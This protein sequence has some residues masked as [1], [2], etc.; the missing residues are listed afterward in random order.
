MAILNGPQLPQMVYMVPNSV[1]G[2]SQVQ[3][4]KSSFLIGLEAV[5][6]VRLVIWSTVDRLHREPTCVYGKWFNVT[7]DHCLHIFESLHLQRHTDRKAHSRV[8]VF[9]CGGCKTLGGC[10]PGPELCLA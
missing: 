5:P 8:V 7:V 2:G 3:Q 4:N 1:K 10:Y 6:C 9:S